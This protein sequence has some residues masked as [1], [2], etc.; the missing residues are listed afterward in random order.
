MRPVRRRRFNP[1]A[2]RGARRFPNASSL[3]WEVFQSARPARGATYHSTTSPDTSAV[4]IRA[5]RE[6]RDI[7]KDK[8]ALSWT[9]FN[10]RA[11]RGARPR[12]RTQKLGRKGFNPRAPRGARQS[13]PGRQSKQIP[14]Q[15]AR[16]ARGAT[17]WMRSVTGT[18][19]VSIR[20]PR[21]GRDPFHPEE[22]VTKK[23]SIRAP[24]E[25]HDSAEGQHMP[26]KTGF[27]PRAPRGARP[28]SCSKAPPSKSFNPRAPRGARPGP[29]PG[30]KHLRGFQSARPARGAT[31]WTGRVYKVANVSIRAPREGRDNR[32]HDFFPLPS[33]FNPRAPRG[34]RLVVHKVCD[35]PFAVSIRAPRE[36]R[37]SV[38][39]LAPSLYACF[40]PRAPRGARPS[41]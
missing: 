27:N 9:R 22:R 21:E 35:R 12:T 33:R 1:R 30:R 39:S 34:A 40:N 3:I 38:P 36:G 4:S 15:S 16:P 31:A 13:H 20:A 25:G 28:A 7:P 2:P 14:F 17:A 6:G 18:V 32:R 24:R 29:R 5:P 37:D 11:P 8:S 23:V 41:C 10:P 19:V 26:S